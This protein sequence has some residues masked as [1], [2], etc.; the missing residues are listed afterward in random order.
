MASGKINV[1]VENIFPLIKKFLYSDHEIFLRELVSNATDATL[2]LKHLTS[3]GEA[4]VEYGNPIIEVKIDKEAKKLHIIDQG[5]GMTADEVEK[6]INQIAFSGAEEFLE[7]YKDSAKDSGVIGHFG[8]GFY[9]AFMVASKV[10]IITKSYKDEPAAHWT[11]D[12]SPEFS[13]VP[14]DKT[15]RG[16]EIILHIAE[17]SLEFLEEYKISELLTKYNKFMPI[18]IKFGTKQEALPKPEDAPEDYKTEYQEI[19]N[20]INNPNP[21]WTKQPVDLTDEDYKKFYHE[22]YPMQFEEPLFNIH[23]NV[24]YPFNLTGILYFPKMSADLQMQKDKIQLY[25][26]QVFVTDN[27]EGI[28]PEFLGMLKGVIDSPDIPLNVSRSYLQADGNVKKI[29]NYI[30]RKVADKLKSLFNENRED[31]EQKWNDIKIV[32]EYGMLSEPKFYE[33]AGDFVLYPTTDDKYF[34]LSELKE[35]IASN[36]TDKNGKLVVL[37]AS[38]KD[39]QHSYIDIAKEKG[40]QVLLLDSPIVSHLIQKLE[41]D[42]ENL[43]FARVDADHIDK[44]IQKDDVQISK[45][46]EDEQ[47]NLKSVLEAIV[48]K[49]NYT[50]QLEPMDSNAAPFMI[51]QPEFMRR[52]KEMSATGGGGMFGMGNFP[53]MYNLV[54]NSNSNLATA[55]LQT[56]DKSAQELLVKQ[57]LDLAKISQGLLKGEELT[58]FVKRSF[59]TLK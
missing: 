44:L 18:P 5:L 57:A 53:D 9:S 17:D 36:Q 41:A 8:L 40:Y 11:C 39:A 4:K 50:V 32:L 37:Y 30:T 19:D 59:E 29:S 38:N 10:E 15:D 3:I 22:L 14:H 1:S 34:T 24:D 48:P 13:L 43:T 26:N 46:S 45:L 51:T 28:V 20:I 6:Y 21:A 42:N 47:T 27:V 33:K 56:E 16:S 2:K 35:T 31:F 58:A 25:Q 55:I 7:K 54:V 52:M 12:G 49:A 23:L